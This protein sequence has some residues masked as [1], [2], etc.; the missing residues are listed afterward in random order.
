MANKSIKYRNIGIWMILLFCIFFIFFIFFYLNSEI[1]TFSDG[2]LHRCITENI[3][4]SQEV[5]MDNPLNTTLFFQ[6]KIDYFPIY[7]IDLSLLSLV[8]GV[9]I[10]NS[11]LIISIFC[12]LL[13]I[14]LILAIMKNESSRLRI[15]SIIFLSFAPIF[16]WIF[17]HRIFEIYTIPL[18]IF[19]FYFTIKWYY[20]QEEIY[21][22]LAGLISII[23]VIAKLALFPILIFYIVIH[24]TGYLKNKVKIRRILFMWI[25]IGLISLPAICFFL[26]NSQSVVREVHILDSTF[27]PRIS[28]EE[29]TLSNLSN[30]DNIEKVIL[31]NYRIR[32][33][34]PF[35]SD[36][37]MSKRFIEI[38][39]YTS[40]Y[41]IT[42]NA[43][44]HWFGYR[45][46]FKSV[47]SLFF[48]IFFYGFI[49]L[50]KSGKIK[51]L[52]FELILLL[53][54]IPFYMV[55]AMIYYNFYVNVLFISIFSLGFLLLIS[56][57]D[58]GKMLKSF[59]IFILI[60][61]L[62]F[63]VYSEIDN[64]LG[65][66]HSI[67]HWD[68]PTGGVSEIENLSE[69][70]IS[71]NITNPVLGDLEGLCSY[72][73]VNQKWDWRLFLLENET[74]FYNYIDKFN[75]TYAIIPKPYMN[76]NLN[77]TEWQQ[78]FIPKNSA[79]Y[80]ILEKGD[81]EKVRESENIILYKF[82]NENFTN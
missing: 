48:I 26:L 9:S 74:D 76:N 27:N 69:Y 70:I 7:H 24:I 43:N 28:I 12:F 79:F 20:S 50:I 5:S 33:K 71:N 19:V 57:N 35:L 15:F 6:K 81:I 64:M 34:L 21:S 29:Q 47:Y 73:Q 40:L 2:V 41:A 38:F 4:Q 11:Y 46:L 1:P 51:R 52:T 54:A 30:Y 42:P 44:Y 8:T 31:N 61:F 60:I 77:I 45:F 56:K 75:I 82:E 78:N 59:I 62:S 58:Y 80:R 67:H 17:A 32:D 68:L 37:L 10:D 13:I 55:S 22:I 63:T 72:S 39:Q 65:Y 23:L 3:I 16:V 18:A 14:T 36:L 25:I 53:C 49:Y 66:K